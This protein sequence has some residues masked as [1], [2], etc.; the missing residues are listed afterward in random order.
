MAVDVRTQVQIDRPR[1]E[2]AAFAADPDNV[3][4]WYTNV[5]SEY[6]R[7]DMHGVSPRMVER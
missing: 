4:R 5:I 1:N 2:V 6:G 3:P 7:D